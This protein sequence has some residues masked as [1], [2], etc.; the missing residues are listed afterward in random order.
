MGVQSIS[1]RAEFIF[2]PHS[3]CF[4]T[5]TCKRQSQTSIFVGTWRILILRK[6]PERSPSFFFNSAACRR[7]VNRICHR[8]GRQSFSMSQRE[9]RGTFPLHLK[10]RGCL[11]ILEFLIFHESQQSPASIPIRK[12]CCWTSVPV[13]STPHLRWRKGCHKGFIVRKRSLHFAHPDQHQPCDLYGSP[14][15]LNFSRAF[16]LSVQQRF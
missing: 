16:E 4:E 1:K 10:P 7:I 9:P 14:C 5:Y 8:S 12:K 2:V 13:A 11:V 6:S 15:H 3:A